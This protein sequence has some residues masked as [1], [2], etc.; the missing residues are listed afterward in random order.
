MSFNWGPV[1]NDPNKIKHTTGG[2]RKETGITEAIELRIRNPC[3][4]C[5]AIFAQD[6]PAPAFGPYLVVFESNGISFDTTTHDAAA[7]L[8]HIYINNC[9]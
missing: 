8:L 9:Y 3:G 7:F 2:T 1:Q 5:D 6:P 4:W